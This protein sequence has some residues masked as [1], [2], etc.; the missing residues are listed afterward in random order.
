MKSNVITAIKRGSVREV[1]KALRNDADNASSAKDDDEKTPLHHAAEEGN[2]Q[3]V[4]ALLTKKVDINALDCNG[5]TPLHCAAEKGHFEVC[6]E[7]LRSKHIDVTIANN[8]DNVALVYLVRLRTEL[9]L[10]KLKLYKRVL[11]MM[12]QRGA[13]VNVINKYGEAPLHAACLRGTATGVSFLL[14][15]SADVNILTPKKETALHWMVHQGKLEMVSLLMQYGA[16]PFVQSS[17]GLTPMEIAVS[18]RH[19]LIISVMMKQALICG[20]SRKECAKMGYLHRYTR[21]GVWERVFCVLKETSLFMYRSDSKDEKPVGSFDI[22][23]TVTRETLSE[24][25]KRGKPNVFRLSNTVRSIYFA[26]ESEVDC[27]DWIKCIHQGQRIFSHS[28]QDT[29]QALSPTNKTAALSPEEILEHFQ[30]ILEHPPNLSC[31]DCESAGAFWMLVTYGALVCFDCASV[32]RALNTSPIKSIHCDKWLLDDIMILKCNGNYKHNMKMESGL[33]LTI[34]KPTSDDSQEVKEQ[35]IKCKYKDDT[36]KDAAIK[37]SPRSSELKRSIAQRIAKYL[38]TYSTSHLLPFLSIPVPLWLNLE[39]NSSIYKTL[40]RG[41]NLPETSEKDQA[42]QVILQESLGTVSIHAKMLVPLIVNFLRLLQQAYTTKDKYSDIKKLFRCVVHKFEELHKL[43]A[44][45]PTEYIFKW[46]LP[47]AVEVLAVVSVCVERFDPQRLIESFTSQTIVAVYFL[48]GE[49]LVHRSDLSMS[50]SP[51]DQLLQQI[52]S[53]K[54]ACKEHSE[55]LR[56]VIGYEQKLKVENEQS[57]TESNRSSRLTR[58]NSTDMMPSSK[59]T[60]WMDQFSPRGEKFVPDDDNNPLLTLFNQSPSVLSMAIGLVLNDVPHFIQQQIMGVVGMNQHF[61]ASPSS[62]WENVFSCPSVTLESASG[63]F[64]AHFDT[65]RSKW[66]TS[67][68][69]ANKPNDHWNLL[70]REIYVLKMRLDALSYL[71]VTWSSPVIWRSWN[72][73]LELLGEVLQLLLACVV[74][75]KPRSFLMEI[76]CSVGILQKWAFSKYREIQNS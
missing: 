56:K 19:K 55:G 12:I 57:N 66:P 62:D 4:K 37:A 3:I 39:Q 42:L 49:Y 52:R 40:Q 13:D 18:K 2:A 31:A 30:R 15:H 17:A 6:E 69:L 21:K 48:T 34:S 23:E 35:Y 68:Q 20:D 60:Y 38:T 10:A 63:I 70:S 14:N 75:Q 73:L 5:W 33:P 43:Y 24:K 59:V 25:Q 47:Q 53:I 8:D 28:N 1:R 16:D 46:W 7:L 51:D 41:L 22:M 58:F 64:F 76:L 29:P 72:N 74:T 9:I 45:K 11:K 54:L 50:P 27:L 61:I 65:L 71:P 32:H 67:E 36:Y 26:V 44:D